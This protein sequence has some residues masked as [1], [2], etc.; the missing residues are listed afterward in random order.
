MEMILGIYFAVNI[1]FAGFYTG[2]DWKWES[3]AY[4]ILQALFFGLFGILYF[5]FLTIY[6]LPAV[7]WIERE[8]RF[9]YVLWFTNFWK[10]RLQEEGVVERIKEKSKNNNRQFK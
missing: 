3:L 8:V 6:S 10:S 9:W 1:F 4:I 5:L 2:R 7:G